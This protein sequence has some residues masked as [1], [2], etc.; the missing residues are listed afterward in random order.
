MFV[1]GGCGGN[2]NNFFTE[3]LCQQE[4]LPLP[5][6]A[7]IEP[8]TK[9]PVAV[10]D[11]STFN[12]NSCSLKKDIGPC[13]AYLEMYFFNVDTAKCERFVYGG[14]MGNENRFQ[15]LKECESSCAHRYAQATSQ[16]CQL[17]KRMGTCRG[18]IERYFYNDTV[19]ECQKFVYSGCDGKLMKDIYKRNV[20]TYYSRFKRKCQQL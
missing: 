15:T 11:P 18:H 7:A 20:S 1:Y 5:S 17:P 9:E 13:L 3:E 14:C 4:C 8:V 19:K 16:V 2:E 6:T 12:I 10:Q